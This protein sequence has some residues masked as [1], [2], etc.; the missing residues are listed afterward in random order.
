[1]DRIYIA[2]IIIA[3]GLFMEGCSFCMENQTAFWLSFSGAFLLSVTGFTMLY[4][5]EEIIEEK[6]Y[7]VKRNNI[8]EEFLRNRKKNGN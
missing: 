3:I 7:E 8:M 2:G 6:Y 4:N 5:E 1:M